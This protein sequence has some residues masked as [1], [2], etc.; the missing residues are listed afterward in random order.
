MFQWILMINQ[1]TPLEGKWILTNVSCFCVF[2]ENPDFNGHKLT[3]E[4]NVL[5]VEN[6][7]EFK[8][9]TNAAGDFTTKWGCNYTPKRTTIYVCN[10]I[11]MFWNSPMLMNL[12]LPMMS[13]FWNTNGVR[14]NTILLKCRHPCNIR[15]CNQ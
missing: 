8:F 5:M 1:T 12:V 15:P 3:F 4:N 6:T 7:G 9:L 11:R 2:G 13:Y 14:S 10:K